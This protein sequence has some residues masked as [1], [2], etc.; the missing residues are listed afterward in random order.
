MCRD[1]V[2]QCAD[3]LAPSCCCCRK[4]FALLVAAIYT[5]VGIMALIGG[6]RQIVIDASTYSLFANLSG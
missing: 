2:L 6:V 1:P 3:A 5:V 4:Y